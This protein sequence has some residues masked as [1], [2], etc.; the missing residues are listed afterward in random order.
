M[1]PGCKIRQGDEI[2][3][4]GVSMTDEEYF[5]IKR[6]NQISN[7]SSWNQ[8]QTRALMEEVCWEGFRDGY[9]NAIDWLQMTGPSMIGSRVGS[10]FDR[11]MPKIHRRLDAI[12]QIDRRR[13]KGDE[14]EVKRRLSVKA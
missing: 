11:N 1:G 2:T 4:E 7:Y 3:E 9:N 10:F 13:E 14:S 6:E 5:S 8:D 12:R